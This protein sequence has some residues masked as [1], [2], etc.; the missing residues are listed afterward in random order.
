M[1]WLPLALGLGAGGMVGSWFGSRA[2]GEAG[3]NLLDVDLYG[4]TYKEGSTDMSSGGGS[5]LDNLLGMGIGGIA[6]LLMLMS[7][8]SQ[9]SQPTIVVID[10]E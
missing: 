6:F 9:P 4:K 3:G 5:G 2:L 7:F 8:N 1:F 10:D